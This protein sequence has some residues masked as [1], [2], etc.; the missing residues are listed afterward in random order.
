LIYAIWNAETAPGMVLSQGLQEGEEKQGQGR[1]TWQCD[2]RPRF[3]V[4]TPSGELSMSLIDK[5]LD[6][7]RQ[8][9]HQA[10]RLLGPG[11][12]SLVIETYVG[13]KQQ[14][15]LQDCLGSVEANVSWPGEG[16]AAC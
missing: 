2:K 5:G 1:F 10:T 6:V 9:K 7:P 8:L 3:D 4:T 15:E 16:G 14:H 11:T 12:T 13:A